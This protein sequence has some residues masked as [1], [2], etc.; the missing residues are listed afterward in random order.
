M[1]AALAA[2]APLALSACGSS[3][4]NAGACDFPGNG[5]CIDYGS[6]SASD[7]DAMKT[8]FCQ[9]AAGTWVSGSCST[10]NRVGTCT[11]KATPADRLLRVYAASGY[12]ATEAKAACTGGDFDSGI[13]GSWSD[14]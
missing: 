1:L 4:H 14:G 2:A 10:S 6:L 9:P 3:S 7:L 5:M 13:A 8:Q 12:S 11:F